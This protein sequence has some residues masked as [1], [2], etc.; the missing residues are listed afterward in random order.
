MP[1]LSAM[2]LFTSSDVCARAGEFT[3][4]GT[5]FAITKNGYLAT[6][7]HVIDG[8]DEI[9]AFDQNK[10]GYTAEVIAVDPS[11]DLAILSINHPTTPL[12]LE[13]NARV[14]KGSE[15]STLGFPNIDFQGYESKFTNGSITAES[16]L[17]G[18]VRFFQISTPIQ[19]GN[20]GG[21]L[22]DSR[23][24]VIGIVSAKLN[25]K[26]TLVKGEV[27]QNVNYAVKVQ[28]LLAMIASTRAVRDQLLQ[29]A[30]K[31]V[32][33]RE[34]VAELADG[35]VY[36]IYGKGK[37]AVRPAKTPA[38][39][40]A[41]S[42]VAPPVLNTPENA[43]A[44]TVPAI[45]L[46]NPQVVTKPGINLVRIGHVGPLTGPIAHLGRD[47]ENGA[48]LAIQDLNELN[49]VIGGQLTKFELIAEDDGADPRQAIS[50]AQR[51]VNSGVKGVVG[52]LNSGTTIPASKIYFQAGIPQISP[53]ATNP[54]Y[55]SQGYGTTYR[56]VANDEVTAGLMAKILTKHLA[57]KRIAIIDDGTVFGTG[58]AYAFKRKAE[59]LG[60]AIVNTQSIGSGIRSFN[61]EIMAIKN[62][63]PDMIFFGGMDNQAIAL[64]QQLSVQGVNARFVGSDGICTAELAQQTKGVIQDNQ[65]F[66]AVSGGVET[67]RVA[68]LDSFKRR[69]K[70][71]FGLDLQIYAPYAYDAV[72]T[73]SMAMK[74]A[75]SV[76]PQ[77]Y[78]RYMKSIK[79]NGV[80]GV[81]SFDVNGDVQQPAITFYTFK[82]GQRVSYG[83]SR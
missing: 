45:T 61:A 36:L 28:Y 74:H 75:D 27:A 81:I 42:S 40:P 10:K 57:A 59:Q 53:S 73:L 43:R 68:R 44:G 39:A 5:A 67:N 55:T 83:V 38:A 1:V 65:V 19:P 79:V 41:P 12:F 9:K 14:R 3:T 18:D 60:I 69:Y 34:D 15:V 32:K 6:N 62:S 51:L 48:R 58:V 7:F 4:S 23:G 35:A 33:S 30:S 70:D 37:E 82:N 13:N 46:V 16:G 50:A 54:R 26:I 71:R 21:P 78:Q 49:L 11:N 47:N 22:L 56:M 24:S 66:C 25:D 2:V 80:T 64:I 63:T 8:L 20:S 76:E 31:T 29:S 17:G 72:Y 77:H 52:H